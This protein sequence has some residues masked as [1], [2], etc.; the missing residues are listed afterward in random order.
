MARA[1]VSCPASH[2]VPFPPAPEETPGEPPAAL[3]GLW[4]ENNWQLCTC[5]EDTLW[6][7]LPPGRGGYPHAQ[8]LIGRDWLMQDD[9][10]VDL[11]HSSVDVKCGSLCHKVT[12]NH[13]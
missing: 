6:F 3:P 5:Q 9:E 1:R 12:N 7:D 13:D 4:D 11:L 10:Q 2:N 8:P